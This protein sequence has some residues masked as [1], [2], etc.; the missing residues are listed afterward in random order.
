MCWIPIF[1]NLDKI[2]KFLINV[3][4]IILKLKEIENLPYSVLLKN[5][6]SFDFLIFKNFSPIF[7]VIPF[8]LMITFTLINS[9]SLFSAQTLSPKSYIQLPYIQ[10]YFSI[11]VF[12]FDITQNELIIL[13]LH[14]HPT[15]LPLFLISWQWEVQ[16]ST[17]ESWESSLTALLLQSSHIQ[18]FT[19]LPA[20]LPKY[21][22]K[23]PNSFQP[24]YISLVWSTINSHFES[25]LMF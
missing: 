16:L 18:S 12:K 8:V 9:R 1:D 17:S 20:G 24:H 11:W 13:T 3:T 25:T 21:L 10:F 23:P 19:I 6:N 15:S 2:D 14:F 5:L 7:P 4:E 22:T